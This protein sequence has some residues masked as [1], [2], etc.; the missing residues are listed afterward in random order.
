MSNDGIFDSDVWL[1][2]KVQ[3]VRTSQKVFW[4]P[5]ATHCSFLIIGGGGGGGGGRYST[6]GGAGGGAGGSGAQMN[7]CRR[8]PRFLFQ[9]SQMINEYF[10]VTIGAGGTGGGSSDIDNATA[11]S[12]NGGGQSK[13]EIYFNVREGAS[14]GQNIGEFGAWG[15]GF[16]SGGSGTVGVN[17]NATSN[18]YGAL[19]GE[20]GG[21]GSLSGVGFNAGNH[22]G[23]SFG[24]N[25]F[26]G[27]MVSGGSGGNGKANLT[28]SWGRAF[29]K[30]Y[31]NGSS[32]PTVTAGLAGRDAFER[33]ANVWNYVQ[34]GHFKEAPYL[35]DMWWFTGVPGPTGGVGGS[36]TTR[37]GR[38]GNGYFGSG[39]GGGAGS[40]N[41]GSGQGGNGG[42]GVAVF[43]WEKLQ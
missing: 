6:T 14:Q 42:D 16:G 17:A 40:G 22:S 27:S 37:G 38:G 15:G 7:Y 26:H 24:T 39:G 30:F 2:A 31:Q 8:F 32:T 12:G 1:R 19:N 21:S 28:T 20:T 4:L 5:G 13:I 10:N 23:N 18:G 36:T 34:E 33:A 3:I 43:W 9:S 35:E 11:N 25:P 29:T 41:T